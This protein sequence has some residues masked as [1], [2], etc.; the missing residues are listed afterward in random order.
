MQRQF[1][2]SWSVLAPLPD[3][4]VIYAA[5]HQIGGDLSFFLWPISFFTRFPA[6]VVIAADAADS[7]HGK[8][9]NFLLTHPPP[10]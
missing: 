7:Q 10:R 2:G 8:L 6:S 5:N 9:I 3:R 4:P 1:F